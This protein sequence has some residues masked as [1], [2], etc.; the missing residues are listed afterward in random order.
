M[1]SSVGYPPHSEI[2]RGTETNFEKATLY[3]FGTSVAVNGSFGFRTN[4][5]RNPG[6]L[7]TGKKM[8]SSILSL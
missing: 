3:F 1:G 8:E 6:V 4:G 2:K 7:K 5:N